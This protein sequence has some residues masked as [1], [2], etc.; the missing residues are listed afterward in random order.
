MK[1][2]VLGLT[3][4]AAAPAAAHADGWIKCSNPNDPNKGCSTSGETSST[5]AALALAGLVAYGI[6]RKRRSR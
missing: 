6:G 1:A 5:A 4:V 3:L 2:I